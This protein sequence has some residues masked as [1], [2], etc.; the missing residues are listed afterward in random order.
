MRHQPATLTLP[1]EEILDLAGSAPDPEVLGS[2]RQGRSLLG[3]HFGRGPL[4]ISLI[5]GCHADEPVGPDLLDRLASYLSAVEHD[6]PLLESAT[7]FLVP[8]ANPDGDAA[9]AHWTT[10]TIETTDHRGRSDRG[11]DLALYARHVVREP[12]GEDVEFGFP[13]DADDRAARPENRAIA[14]FLRR[15]APFH[16]HG[17]LHGMAFAPGPW[18]LIERAWIERTQIMRD[19]L[20]R[21]VDDMGYGLLDWDRQGDKGFDRIDE[22][23]STRPDSRAMI[24][25][26]RRLGDE[27]MASL[28]RPSSMELVRSLGGDALTFVSEMPLF[29]HPDPLILSADRTVFKSWLTDVVSLDDP[30]LIKRRFDEAG[31]R[32]MPIRDQ[33]RLQLAFVEEAI[34]AVSIA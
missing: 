33:M 15:G 32:P 21:R 18:F 1:S 7:W 16:I 3:Y 28:F 26:F 25:H 14:D 13:R 2:S 22:G 20:R 12:P 27:A 31:I 5:A 17:S 23:F 34:K 24:E 19:N 9:N 10:R 4:G 29:L 11:F 8:H 6:H 30:D